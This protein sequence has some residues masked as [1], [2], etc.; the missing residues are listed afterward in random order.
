MLY[1]CTKYIRCPDVDLEF[2]CAISRRIDNRRS[3]VTGL[4]VLHVSTHC[5]FLT[6]QEAVF[7]KLSGFYIKMKHVIGKFIGS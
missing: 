4:Q 5:A 3:V 2:M 1:R 7:L 6:K